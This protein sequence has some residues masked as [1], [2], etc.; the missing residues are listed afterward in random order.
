MKTETKICKDCKYWSYESSANKCKHTL[1]LVVNESTNLITGN[2]SSAIYRDCEH[3]RYYSNCG[4][5][6]ELFEPRVILFDKVI[7]L[8]KLIKGT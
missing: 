8:I 3:M 1:S 5:Q 2:V 4:K 6:G 7:K